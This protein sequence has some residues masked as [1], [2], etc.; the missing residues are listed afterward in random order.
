MDLLTSPGL[1]ALSPGILGG[2]GR[3]KVMCDPATVG[4]ASAGGTQLV[5]TR[6]PIEHRTSTRENHL[7]FTSQKRN[8]SLAHR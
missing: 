6:S 7:H 4:T 8:D 3:N 2:V 1:E 5:G